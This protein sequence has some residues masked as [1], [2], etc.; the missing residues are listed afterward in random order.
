MGARFGLARRI[1]ECFEMSVAL[2]L[3]N[4]IC[5]N[6]FVRFPQRDPVTG[7]LCY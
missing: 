4:G 2:F 1:D 5:G 6:D 3:L 7:F